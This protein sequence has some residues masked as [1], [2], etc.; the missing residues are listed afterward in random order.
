MGPVLQNQGRVN[1]AQFSRDDS[2]I[3][4]WSNDGTAR[5]WDALTG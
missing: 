1:G 2:R 3:L 4:A 5:L